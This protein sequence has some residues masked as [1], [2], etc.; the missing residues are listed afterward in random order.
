VVSY[1]NEDIVDV[2][3]Q[4]PAWNPPVWFATKRYEQYQSG[5]LGSTPYYIEDYTVLIR[6]YEE[7]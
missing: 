2:N 5:L 3:D 7:E 1:Y 6:D 4:N